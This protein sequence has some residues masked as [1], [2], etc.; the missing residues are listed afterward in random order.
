[1]KRRNA[2]R[3]ARASARHRGSDPRAAAAA[4][5]RHQG[6]VAPNIPTAAATHVLLRQRGCASDDASFHIFPTQAR[7]EDGRDDLIVDGRRGELR[8]HRLRRRGPRHGLVPRPAAA[9]RR[10]PARA[11]VGRRRAL[12]F[13]SRQGPAAREGLRRDGGQVEGEGR[14]VPRLR[15]QRFAVLGG[16]VRHEDRVDRRADLRQPGLLPPGAQGGRDAHLARE[17]RRAVG[18]RARGHGRRGQG[19]ERARLHG[20]HQ[21]HQPLLHG[22]ARGRQWEPGSSS[23]INV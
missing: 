1:M 14:P 4:R 18:S 22:G 15:R 17:A 12:L 16:H 3:P 8:H 5:L 10:D 20:L 21:E 7:H 9:E 13:R 11:A 6:R 19:G 2:S 23:D